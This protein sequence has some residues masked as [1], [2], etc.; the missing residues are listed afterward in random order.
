MSYYVRPS[1]CPFARISVDVTGW[2]FVKF[3]IG[4]LYENPSKNS[5]LVNL[6]K[7]ILDTLH[8]VS[9]IVTGNIKSPYKRFLKVEWYQPLGISDGV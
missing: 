8:D 3:D 4:D 5:N 9:F 2:I 6:A 7:K 1:F